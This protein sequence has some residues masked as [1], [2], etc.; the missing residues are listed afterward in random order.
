ML[1][2][3]QINRDNLLFYN[4]PISIEMISFMANHVRDLLDEEDVASKKLFKIFIELTQNVSYYSAKVAK[5]GNKTGSSKG[6]GYVSVDITEEG[7]SVTTGNLIQVSH[8][9]VLEKNCDEIN[10]LNEA[11]LRELKRKTR[12]QAAVRDVGAHIGLIHTGLIS[13]SKLK[14]RI[15]PIDDKHSFF[16]ISI[17]IAN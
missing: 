15:D 10:K 9:P 14:S 8:G 12:I 1:E 2:N 7:Y 4:G 5:G 16:T 6:V 17:S 13:G 11:E 3:I